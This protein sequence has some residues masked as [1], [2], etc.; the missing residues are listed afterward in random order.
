MSQKNMRC[1]E[2]IRNISE[3]SDMDNKHGA[4][5]FK[6]HRLICTA[7]NKTRSSFNGNIMCSFHAEINVINLIINTYLKSFKMPIDKVRRK[8]K[9]YKI[10]TCR[11]NLDYEST[12]C[13]DCIN[14]IK[15]LGIENIIF[16]N[17]NII[18]K[19]NINSINN[20]RSPLNQEN[21]Y[22]KIRNLNTKFS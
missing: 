20:R 2:R 22:I 21:K 9:K 15:Q 1:I 16:V 12:P 6:G 17:N 10:I 13:F 8:M 5:L 19:V 11:D 14:Q 3:K 18:N 7:Y 4:G